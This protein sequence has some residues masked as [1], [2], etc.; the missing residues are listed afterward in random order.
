MISGYMDAVG[1]IV[2]TDSLLFGL[3]IRELDNGHDPSEVLG[4]SVQ[5]REE[6]N[7]W[8]REFQ[9]VVEDVLGLNGR[10]RLSFYL[11]EYISW[12]GELYNATGC[13]RLKCK[14]LR[15]DVE[16]QVIH[17]IERTGSWTYLSIITISRKAGPRVF[18]T[19]GAFDSR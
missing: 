19:P 4:V 1:R 2:T 14:P 16:T 6:V 7:N 12:F 8:S 13:Y 17:Q 9:G 11:I 15:P 10:D 3:T 5:Q 18:N